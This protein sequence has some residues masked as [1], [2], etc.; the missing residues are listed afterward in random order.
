MSILSPNKGRWRLRASVAPQVAA[1]LTGAEGSAG[2]RIALP[3]LDLGSRCAGAARRRLA[4]G[5][6]L[7]LGVAL[8]GAVRGV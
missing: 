4:T 3:R 7:G 8:E 1:P 2:P 6:N 5:D